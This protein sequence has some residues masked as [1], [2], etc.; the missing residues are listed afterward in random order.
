MT[1]WMHTVGLILVR[2]VFPGVLGLISGLLLWLGMLE[3][4]DAPGF[5]WVMIATGGAGVLVSLA[6]LWRL[7]NARGREDFRWYVVPEGEVEEAVP[8]ELLSDEDR[9]R[10]TRELAE[11]NRRW[12]EALEAG[13]LSGGSLAA[14][15]ILAELE[16]RAAALRHRLGLSAE[17]EN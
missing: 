12:R 7:N 14:H 5:A 15:E 16:E 10:L 9:E 11:V 1:P 2:I 3:R 17:Q 6:V 13:F 8:P 4:D